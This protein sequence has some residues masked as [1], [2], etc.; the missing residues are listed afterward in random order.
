MGQTLP[1]RP[2]SYTPLPPPKRK[3]EYIVKFGSIKLF[4]I[5]Y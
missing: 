2:R 5:K 4:T 3:K 1:V